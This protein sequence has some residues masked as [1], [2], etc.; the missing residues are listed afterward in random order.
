M[1]RPAPPTVVPRTLKN[2]RGVLDPERHGE[3][4]KFGVAPKDADYFWSVVVTR[5]VPGGTDTSE[6]SGYSSGPEP[7]QS[8]LRRYYQSIDHETLLGDKIEEFT[9]KL[10]RKG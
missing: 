7:R 9:A 2:P 5:K 8:T 1:I 6:L 3:Q 10:T 4:P